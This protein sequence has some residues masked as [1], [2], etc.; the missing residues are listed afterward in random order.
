MNIVDVMTVA[1]IALFIYWGL[2]FAIYLATGENEKFA[3]YWCV[4][5][6]YWLLYILL[7]P[8]RFIRKY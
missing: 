3:V 5:L 2:G 7:A 6:V 8:V 1:I 4:G